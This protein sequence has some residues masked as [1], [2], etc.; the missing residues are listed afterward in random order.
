MERCSLMSII[1]RP[2]LLS[3]VF[4]NMLSNNV[5][6]SFVIILSFVITENRLLLYIVLIKSVV[7][8]LPFGF[9]KSISKTPNTT[10]LISS[11]IFPRNVSRQVAGVLHIQLMIMLSELSQSI[12]TVRLL[13][14]PSIVF[15]MFSTILHLKPASTYIGT[16]L[17]LLLILLI[18]NS[19]YPS[20]STLQ[21][22][23]FSS[24]ISDTAITLNCSIY[25]NLM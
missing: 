15:A 17:C 2:L 18:S 8:L 11:S 9:N 4:V 1:S 21:L 24:Q 7:F 25:N 23:S 6:E 16:P 22:F 12:S 3:F 13:I 19:S 20:S 14:L 10:L 5:A